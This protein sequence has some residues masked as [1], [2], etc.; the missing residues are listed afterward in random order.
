MRAVEGRT[1]ASRSTGCTS[2]SAAT[3]R[4]SASSGRST[5]SSTAPRRTPTAPSARGWMPSRPPGTSALPTGTA[6]G[7]NPFVTSFTGNTDLPGEPGAEDRR[8][9]PLDV[10]LRA[11]Q[12]LADF[13][14]GVA[15][16][17]PRSGHLPQHLRSPCGI[18]V[19]RR[20]A[21]PGRRTHGCRGTA[22]GPRAGLAPG[23]R[24]RGGPTRPG[25]RRRR[26]P[27]PGATPCARPSRVTRRC[28]GPGSSSTSW[29]P[30]SRAWS[31]TA[32]CPGGAGRPSTT[33]TTGSGSRSTVQH[34]RRW[35][36]PSCAACTT[37]PSPT[38]AGTTAGPA[39]RRD[40]VSSSPGACSSTSRGRSSG[41]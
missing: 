37:S 4:R 20:T 29:R 25:A 22:R 30:A 5:A 1:T 28:A 34:R 21:H 24:R 36:H 7:W 17:R 39:S 16:P 26:G 15:A 8:L 31:S 32:S 19:R 6:I 23:R 11:V 27:A 10:A 3:T 12:L 9:T 38:R 14:R 2:S 35:S 40:S 41:A 18:D 13:H 33:S